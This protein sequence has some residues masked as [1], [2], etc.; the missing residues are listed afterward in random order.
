[1]T[2]RFHFVFVC[3]HKTHLHAHLHICRVFKSLVSFSPE[4]LVCAFNM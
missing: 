2:E 3:V 1:M 4:S